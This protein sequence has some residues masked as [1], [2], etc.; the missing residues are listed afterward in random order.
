MSSESIPPQVRRVY[1]PFDLSSIPAFAGGFINFGCWDGIDLD[2]PLTVADRVRSQ[3]RMYQHVLTALTGPGWDAGSTGG[4]R[5]ERGVL[6]VGCGL[7][8]GCALAVEEFGLPDVTGMDIHPEQLERAA[9]ANE[10]LLG[11][12]PERLRFRQG[13]AEAMPFGDGRF[14]GVYSVEAVQHFRDLAAFGRECARVLAPGGRL[15]VA[16]FLTPHEDPGAPERLAAMLDSYADGLDVAHP[17]GTLTGSLADA[18]LRAVRTESIGA[19]VWPGWDRWLATSGY[20][21]TWSR[22]FLTA[23]REGLLD[24]YLITAEAP[25][26]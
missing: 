10:R 7:G 3:Q 1:G 25:A 2:G 17:L 16:G 14:G 18:G 6:E 19:L 22:N 5:R 23:Y 12:S 9:R 21:T 26:G 8:L 11:E 24:Y 4:A 15:A 20:T 13:A